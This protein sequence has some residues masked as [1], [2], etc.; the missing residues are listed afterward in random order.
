MAAQA[1]LLHMH[2][3]FLGTSSAGENCKQK[4]N[5]NKFP[6]AKLGEKNPKTKPTKGNTEHPAQK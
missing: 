4:R 2:M 3:R 1:S 5:E 6:R